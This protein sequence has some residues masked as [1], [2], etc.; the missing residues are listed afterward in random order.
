M[1]THTS[2]PTLF[3]FFFFFFNDTATTEI[4]TLSLHDALPISPDRQIPP[5]APAADR[6]PG[7]RIGLEGP[8]QDDVE[9]HEHDRAPQADRGRAGDPLRMAS[10]GPAAGQE[11]REHGRRQHDERLQP[12]PAAARFGNESRDQEKE[13]D[14]RRREGAQL[15]AAHHHGAEIRAIRCRGGDASR[16]AQP[17]LAAGGLWV[18][19]PNLARRAHRANTSSTT[20]SVTAHAAS[21][22]YIPRWCRAAVHD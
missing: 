20:T 13:H 16:H 17:L 21:A 15:R 3:L 9:R 10:R 7:P 6:V 22:R 8:Q 2:L 11:A 12:A 19:P 5:A 4:Y 1:I 18:G 14:R